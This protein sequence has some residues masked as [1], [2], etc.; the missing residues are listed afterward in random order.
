MVDGKNDKW[1]YCDPECQNLPGFGGNP[2]PIYFGSRRRLQTAPWV[3]PLFL[4]LFVPRILPPLIPMVCWH[5]VPL[6]APILAPLYAL[7]F[8]RLKQHI[9]KCPP[10][11]PALMTG[12]EPLLSN[13]F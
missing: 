5:L 6:H 7:I 11:P 1:G 10:M 2:G 8:A 13:I 9:C 12:H 3:V 4:P